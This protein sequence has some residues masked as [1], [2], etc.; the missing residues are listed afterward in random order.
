MMGAVSSLAHEAPY[1]MAVPTTTHHGSGL[2]PV[3]IVMH[4]PRMI[5]D[6]L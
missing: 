2:A 3:Y 4:Q 1:G 5:V 6:T